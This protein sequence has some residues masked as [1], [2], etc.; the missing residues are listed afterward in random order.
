MIARLSIAACWIASA[1]LAQAGD[2]AETFPTSLHATRPGKAHWY[3]AANGGFEKWT[4]VEIGTLGCAQCH[5]AS[6]AD[7]AGYAEPYPG[8]SCA[9]C[10]A[11][12]DH[13]V[14]QDR[15]LGCHGRQAAEAGRLA[16]PDVHRDAGMVC[17]DCHGSEDVHGDGEVYESML[18]PGA[19]K[20]DCA[21]CHPSSE[22]PESHAAHDPH[23]GALHCTACHSSTVVT[24][25]NCHFESQ[26]EAG[27]RRAMR[28]LTGFVLLVNR[29]KDDTVHAATFQS[30]TH[31]GTAFVA[32]APYTPHATVKQGRRCG[33][34]H[35]NQGE[36]SN[37]AAAGYRDTGTIPLVTW[38]AEL[39]VLEWLRG[40]VP[41]PP[42][43]RQAIRMEFMTFDGDPRSAPGPAAGTWSPIGTDLPDG[44]QMLFASPLTE[45]QMVKLGIRVEKLER[46]ASIPSP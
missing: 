12:A 28:P 14:S 33:E 17:W 15:C 9:D 23:D 29:T 41:V 37:A 36:P 46:V 25:Y 27:V 22:L 35:L 40:V 1:V 38:N 4:G 24:C 39:G 8:A 43:F 19:I 5:G 45:A 11:T 32:F 42:D 26:V 21:G 44:S 13:S 18:E 16:L 6:D 3:S 7:G 10:H 20:A 34:C 30:L 31:R 2:P